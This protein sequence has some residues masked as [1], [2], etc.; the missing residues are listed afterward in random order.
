MLTDQHKLAICAAHFASGEAVSDFDAFSVW[1]KHEGLSTELKHLLTAHN[2]LP[3]V[4][5]V[6]RGVN[7]APIPPALTLEGDTVVLDGMP[8]GRLLTWYRTAL[9]Q[10]MQ[11]RIAYDSLIDRFLAH[12]AATR[13]VVA[14]SINDLAVWAFAPSSAEAD[15]VT[16]WPEFMQVAFSRA[17]L[18]KSFVLLM[19][20]VKLTDRGFGAV[21]FPIATPAVAEVQAAFYLAT[22]E[23]RV[24]YGS[25]A[26]K[27]A[28][29]RYKE[30]VRRR[31]DAEQRKQPA[32]I[33]ELT[34]ELAKTSAQ[35]ADA[36][37]ANREQFETA[38]AQLARQIPPDT[39]ARLRQ[40]AARFNPLARNQFSYGTVQ[41]RTGNPKAEHVRNSI[42]D[43][44]AKLAT[45][46]ADFALPCPLQ[47]EAHLLMVR[48]AGDKQGGICYA[49]GRPLAGLQGGKRKRGSVPTLTANRFILAAPSQRL[50]SGTA[51]EQ[52]VVC[53]TCATVAMACPIKLTEGNIIVRMS[54]GEEGGW[55]I[56]DYLRMLTLGEL[57]LVAGRY[58]LLKCTETVQMQKRGRTASVP[59]SDPMGPLQYALFKIA[60]TLPRDTLRSCRVWLATGSEKELT[61]RWMIWLNYLQEIFHLQLTL[62]DQRSNNHRAN[63]AAFEAVRLVQKE[64]VIKAIYALITAD[65]SEARALGTQ[66][67][68]ELRLLDEL[69]RS[70]CELLEKEE[71]MMDKAQ[72]FRHV[73]ALTGLLS[74]FCNFV[75]R[76]CER[77]SDTAKREVS[78]LIE[79]VTDPYQFCYRA[80]HNLSD[81]M[82][83]L[84]RNSDNYF[85]FDEAE[86]LLAGLEGINLI[87]RQ[88]VSEQKTR[89]L[90]VYFDDV[91]HAYTIL[92]E[93]IY[94]NEKEQKDFTTELKLSLAAKFPEYFVKKERA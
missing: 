86:K 67:F 28:D 37:R 31:R 5:R 10:E 45:A 78:K 58:L 36:L 70:H 13:K 8:I 2:A 64:E 59:V 76:R 1:A 53:H 12:L 39:L 52:P 9:P 87:E 81:E 16:A 65:A 38:V 71:S 90:R 29:T 42:E 19:N 60:A 49:C 20:S 72:M 47:T 75:D 27:A 22:L 15:L 73:A 34:A 80:T 33:E 61:T 14:L 48:D 55:G 30:L 68:T 21:E 44:I 46:P 3:W 26:Y 79:E 85:C 84:Y 35:R 11:A 91:R 40:L 41:A 77:G 57:N 83:T 89:T 7:A 32:R 51:Q 6:S 50:Q 74:G 69:R 82:A 56:A 92:F 23:Q 66:S 88:G 24:L 93:A 62:R 18:E 4:R 17:E 25:D 63:Q 54:V 43:M 94:K